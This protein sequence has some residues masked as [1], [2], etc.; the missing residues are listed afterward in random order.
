VI[1]E[2]DRPDRPPAWLADARARL[3]TRIISTKNNR[4]TRGRA[5]RLLESLESEVAI[6][7]RIEEGTA[8]IYM[9][10]A[11]GEDELI[12]CVGPFGMPSFLFRSRDKDVQQGKLK[13][14]NWA[15]HFRTLVGWVI[16]HGDPVRDEERGNPDDDDEEELAA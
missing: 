2:A 12:V 13:R 14:N 6:P 15:A 10:W 3:D 11:G 9:R 5:L 8:G 7:E 16:P 4:D 1:D